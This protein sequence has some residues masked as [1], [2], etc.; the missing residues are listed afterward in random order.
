MQSISQRLSNSLK[1]LQLGPKGA[2]RHA[3]AVAASTSSVEEASS[4]AST[5]QT[6]TPAS[7]RTGMLAKKLGMTAIYDSAGVR[8]P[9][10]VLQV[11]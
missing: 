5:S 6:W 1:A 2:V 8:T 11:S 10:T 7:R 9:V 4:E 3:S